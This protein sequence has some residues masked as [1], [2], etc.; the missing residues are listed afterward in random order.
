MTRRLRKGGLYITFAGLATALNLGSQWVVLTI[1]AM[2]GLGRDLMLAPA[3][4]TGTGLALVVKYL[5]DKTYIFDDR[6]TGIR[7][8]ARK[9]SLYTGVG[10]FTTLIAWATEYAFAIASSHSNLIYLGGA[11]G[12]ALGY[13]VRY[14][15]DGRLVFQATSDEESP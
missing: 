1:G 3:L 4:V 14:Q 13:G 5:L 12:A 15:L 2:Q 6:G 9:F 11:L 10:L 7:A 8:H